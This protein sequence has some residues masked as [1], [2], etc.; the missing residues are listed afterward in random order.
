[1]MKLT[2]VG[3]TFLALASLSTPVFAQRAVP[4]TF[5]SNHPGR[6]EVKPG[7]GRIAKFVWCR[8]GPEG[9]SRDH[10]KKEVEGGN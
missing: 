3:L 6:Q 5:E 1:M 10:C 8:I 4:M 9:E 7:G 2:N